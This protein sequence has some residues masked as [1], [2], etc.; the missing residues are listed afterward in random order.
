[1]TFP[2]IGRAPR[3]PSLHR[4]SAL[5]QQTYAAGRARWRNRSH[6]LAR[7]VRELELFEAARMRGR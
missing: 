2:G 3:Y 5:G 4:R 6:Q 1:M 7:E